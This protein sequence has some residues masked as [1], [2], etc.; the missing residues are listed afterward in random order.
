M[1]SYWHVWILWPIL[2][3]QQLN[4]SHILM[5]FSILVFFGVVN[6]RCSL[7][8]ST[9]VVVCFIFGLTDSLVIL[10]HHEL[11]KSAHFQDVWG[12]NNLHGL[13]KYWLLSL[14]SLLRSTAIISVSGFL[15]QQ[16]YTI[17]SEADIC[18]RQEES[19]VKIST[20]LSISRVAASILL[21]HYNW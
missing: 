6:I 9:G 16:N 14:L 3:L 17:L 15:S 11:L 10:A 21:R 18:Q 2:S 12:I 4:M 1:I 20:V 13:A 7:L 19:I 5:G 8:P